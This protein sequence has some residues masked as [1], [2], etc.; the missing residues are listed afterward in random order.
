MAADLKGKT[1]I[2]TGAAKR[3][4][5]EIALALAAE[6]VNV[7]AHYNSSGDEAEGLRALIERSGVSSWL[8]RADFETPDDYEKLIEKAADAAGR[9]DILVNSASIFPSGALEEIR[10]DDVMRNVHVNAWVPF[11]LSR[12][13]ARRTDRGV[14]INLLDTR[15]E[16]Y[17]FDHAAY[18]LSKHMLAMFTEMTALEYAPGIRVNAVA[19]GLVLPP[20]G[21]DETF[22]DKMKDGLPLRRH[23]SARDVADAVIFLLKSEFITGQTIF[24]DGGRHLREKGSG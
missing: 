10:F 18:I 17:D 12:S 16:G 8:L 2:V 21:R 5:R 20:P 6:G 22:L 23:G 19:P 24:V 9:L 4:G 13:F 14:I 1:A 3:L 15:I 11:A 7:V